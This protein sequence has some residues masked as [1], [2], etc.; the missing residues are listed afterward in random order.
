MSFTF[1]DAPAIAPHEFVARLPAGLA[2]SRALLEALN[3]QLALPSYFGFNWN[4][5]SDCL[6]D[7]SWIQESRVVLCHVDVPPLPGAELRLYLQVLAEA[8]AS[9]Q[10]GE[11]HSLRVIFPEAARHALEAL[12]G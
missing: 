10:P 8:V 3:T 1:E 6:R 2:T 12:R 4:A 7:L 5:L 9:W 11:G